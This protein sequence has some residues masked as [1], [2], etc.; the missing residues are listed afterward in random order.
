MLANAMV[1]VIGAVF[2]IPLTYLIGPMGMGIYGSAYDIWK[3][4]FIIA[5]AGLPVAVS[6]MVA[7]S[8]AGHNRKEAHKIFRVSFCLL[9]V[10]GAAGTA[11][12]FF[13]AETFSNLIGNSQAR[14]AVMAMAPSLFFVA[15][16]ASV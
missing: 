9:I 16:M 5:T 13:G 4:L 3:W 14:L 11:I 8:M 2:K 6:K 12:L 10:I 7:E 15:I 1:K